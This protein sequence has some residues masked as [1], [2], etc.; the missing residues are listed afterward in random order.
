MSASP[1]PPDPLNYAPPQPPPIPPPRQPPRQFLL[2]FLGGIAISLIAWGLG[3]ETIDKTAFGFL[4]FWGVIGFKLIG[5]ITLVCFPIRRLIG[6]GLLVS[7]PVGALIFF[8][9]C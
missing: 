2:G 9:S 3:W 6:I 8:G 5:G 7:L 1:F 4:I